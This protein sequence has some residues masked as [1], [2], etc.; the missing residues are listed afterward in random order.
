M[1][2]QIE[3]TQTLS[4]LIFIVESAAQSFS[5][6]QGGEPCGVRCAEYGCVAIATVPDA[7]HFGPVSGYEFA[8]T[9]GAF[10]DSIGIG[11]LSLHTR[12][13]PIEFS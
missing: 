7:P 10:P 11:L 4:S 9:A 8:S 2:P 3:Q 6:C 5:A 13:V 1:E 12:S